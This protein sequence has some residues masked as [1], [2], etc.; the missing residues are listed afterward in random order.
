MNDNEIIELLDNCCNSTHCYGC[1][2]ADERG[3]ASHVA[4]IAFDL[5]NRQK[6]EIE[7]FRN[8]PIIRLFDLWRADVEA[9]ARKEFAN[10]VHTEIR[11]ALESNYKAKNERL[12]NPN[13]TMADEFVSYCEGKISALRWIDGFVK[14]NYYGR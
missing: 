11:Q 10:K 3:C 1:Q 9:D 14:E 5:I 7:N 6:A 8:T 4:Q 12:A 13:I 2:F